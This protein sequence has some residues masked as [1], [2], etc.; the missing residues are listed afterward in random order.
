MAVGPMAL[1]E[2]DRALRRP[3]ART[4]A[5][6]RSRPRDGKAMCEARQ[7]AGR[8][9]AG[10]RIGRCAGARDV[11]A[12]P[13]LSVCRTASGCWPAPSGVSDRQAT[14][15][16]AIDWSWD[17]LTPWEQA[18][19]AQCRCSTAASRWRPPKRCWTSARWPDAP[20]AIDAVQALVDKSLLRAVGAES[21]AAVRHRRTV[22]R[23][24]PQHP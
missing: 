2:G 7:A 10:H 23:H 24:V 5:R 15:R 13:S 8:S 19:L 17:L 9:A 16:A 6:I 4:P 14:L 12:A 1:D 3:S 18:A 21:A 20:P 11:A 22:L